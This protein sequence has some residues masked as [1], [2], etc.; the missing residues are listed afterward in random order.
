MQIRLNAGPTEIPKGLPTSGVSIG[1]TART[2]NTTCFYTLSNAHSNH[3]IKELDLNVGNFSYQEL[4][5]DP[6]RQKQLVQL[7]RDSNLNELGTKMRDAIRGKR[8]IDLGCGIPTSS[9]IPRIVAQLFGALD[10]IGVDFEHVEDGVVKNEF[11]EFGE[12]TSRFAKSDLINATERISANVTKHG[13]NQGLVFYMSGIESPYRNND[14]VKP[15]VEKICSQV[16]TSISGATKSGDVII[17]GPKTNGFIPEDYGF[18][19]IHGHRINPMGVAIDQW[20]NDEKYRQQLSMDEW[21]TVRDGK[22]LVRKADLWKIEKYGESVLSM[23]PNH[24]HSIYLK[25]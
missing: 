3:L 10:Y 22:V 4:V 17:L 11:P 15:Q 20:L 7:L 21:T 25:T 24:F 5:Q 23:S 19:C 14:K 16:L 13:N 18:E 1:S 9:F 8:F 6:T 2:Q 12:F